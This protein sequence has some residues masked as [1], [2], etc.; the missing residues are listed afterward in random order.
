[1]TYDYS[2]H[3]GACVYCKTPT[4]IEPKAKKEREI[5]ISSKLAKTDKR[6]WFR[7]HG[8][9]LRY[10]D[11][12]RALVAQARKKAFREAAERSRQMFEGKGK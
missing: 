6:A 12:N 10:Y 11:R 4:Q 3:S 7:R 1:V 8:E 5:E 9:A 2:H